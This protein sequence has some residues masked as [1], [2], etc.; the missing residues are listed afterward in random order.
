[1]NYLL[2]KELDENIINVKKDLWELKIEEEENTCILILA[3]VKKEDSL[4]NCL[5]KI[6]YNDAITYIQNKTKLV[7]DNYNQILD[8][9]NEISKNDKLELITDEHILYAILKNGKSEAIQMLEDFNVNTDMM[10]ITVNEYLELNE[11]NY[12]TNI[13]EEV[14]KR[15]T[16]PYVGR[17]EYIDKVIRILN[18]KQ[19]NNCMLLGDA[20]VGKSALVE[21]VARRL[22]D[23]GHEENIYR[24]EIGGIVAGTRYRGDLEERIV[25]VIKKIKEQKAIL[26]IDE[27]HT[28]MG[29]NKGEESLSIGNILKPMLSRNDIK[30]IGATTLEE[31]YLYVDKDK[32][33]VRRFQNIIIPEP[34][35]NETTNI[36]INIKHLYEEY[37][38]IKYSKKLIENIVKCGKYFPN[39][40]NPDKTIDLLDELGAYSKKNKITRPNIKHLK[41]I[42]L[43][44]LNMKFI[45]NKN[46]IINK[47][48]NRFL[49]IDNKAKT[50]VNFEYYGDSIDKLIKTVTEAFSLTESNIIELNIDLFDSEL[51]NYMLKTILESPIALINIKNFHNAPF[52]LEK[53]IIGMLEQGKTYDTN[54]KLIY[55][56]NC[57]FIFEG[58]KISNIGYDKTSK[59]NAKSYIDELIIDDVM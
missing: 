35:I 18:K 1:M 45:D 47:Y 26:F 15:K 58:K 30:C 54:K 41:S 31:Y 33:F 57:I 12:I 3:M 16:N 19:K 36:L 56:S 55:L 2:E 39:L 13:T 24:L 7:K 38:K 49:D 32:A 9:A 29:S 17:S 51:N 25:D 28:I 23:E 4:L 11:E 48:Y 44:N 53:R 20:G 22:I 8:E 37:Y 10:L 6:K 40:K 14:K 46:K 5:C 52:I 42:V 27:I 21:G 43:E 34:D 50:I 59:I